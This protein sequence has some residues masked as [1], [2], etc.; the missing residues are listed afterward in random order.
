MTAHDDRTPGW[1]IAL[2]L[3]GVALMAAKTV[4][5]KLGLAVD[6]GF[7]AVLVAAVFAA[8]HHAEV[9]A[10]RIGEPFGTL[11]L[12]LAVTIIES[13]L[14]VSAMLAGGFG[15]AGLARDTVFAAVMIICNGVVG[16]CLLLGGLRHRLQSFQAA[17]ANAPLATLLALTGMTMVLPNFTSSV[18]GP[19]YNTPQLIF[20]SV[21][22]LVLWGSF[23]FVQTVRHRSFFLPLGEPAHVQ[24]APPGN[25][26]ALTSALLLPVAL[27]AV[28][29]LA[30]ALTP[31]FERGLNRLGA[32]A[33]M[34]GVVIAAI[35]LLPEGLAAVR[36][37]REDR[38]QTSINLALGSAVASVGL[39]IPVVAAVSILQGTTLTLGLGA[40]DEVF[41]GLTFLLSMLTFSSGQTTILP[42]VLHL[43]FFC[44]YL[45]LTAVP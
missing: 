15:A 8:V 36:A 26:L 19:E 22:S 30:K 34:L 32:P 43:V 28:V 33:A 10:H 18:P 37:A 14:I 42:G 4:L 23:I 3:L 11:V 45:F 13:A 31:S 20:A 38:L 17:G 39:T 40:R 5:P 41:L 16:L 1:A 27:V 35:V 7:G 24:A 29:G 12:A 25:R 44:A 21:V 6:I 2:P 9:I